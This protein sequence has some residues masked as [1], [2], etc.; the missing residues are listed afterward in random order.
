MWTG[1]GGLRP[2]RRCTVLRGAPSSLR[3]C[4][5][6]EKVTRL[7]SRSE[8]RASG[9]H[10][11]QLAS[12]RPT[13][14]LARAGETT[15]RAVNVAVGPVV[16]SVLPCRRERHGSAPP[17]CA[18]S[19]FATRRHP[20]V[21]RARERRA[22]RVARRATR[23]ARKRSLA[24]RRRGCAQVAHSCAPTCSSETTAGTFWSSS[25]SGSADTRAVPAD[26]F[27]R[28][29]RSGLHEQCARPGARAGSIVLHG[30]DTLHA[31][32]SVPRYQQRPHPF[33]S[34]SSR[35]RRPL[36]TDDETPCLFVRRSSRNVGRPR[37]RPRSKR[38]HLRGVLEVDLGALGAW[39][40]ATRHRRMRRRGCPRPRPHESVLLRRM[41]SANATC[42]GTRALVQVQSGAFG[43]NEVTAE[44]SV[45]LALSSSSTKNVCTTGP[46]ARPSSREM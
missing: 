17:S 31:K 5:S 2:T 41:M 34:S 11:G 30:E 28:A 26:P 33:S 7:R 39:M 18:P 22:A 40:R 25:D 20:H 1:A 16:A 46:D 44:S 10:R 37:G 36:D 4:P 24:G 8:A 42:S 6:R 45:R 3:R 14:T 9:A 12:P 13:R 21:R 38:L 27:A 29:T 43:V 35:G 15:C 32:M 23:W 19:S